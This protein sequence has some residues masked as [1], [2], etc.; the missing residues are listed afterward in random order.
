MYPGNGTFYSGVVLSFSVTSF[1]SQAQTVFVQLNW[2][3]LLLKYAHSLLGLCSR[4]EPSPQAKSF[5][6]KRKKAIQ[7]HRHLQWGWYLG[8][9]P[10]TKG[11]TAPC[12]GV[13]WEAS[14]TITTCRG[15]WAVLGAGAW[16]RFW[17]LL[18]LLFLTPLQGQLPE[19]QNQ[20]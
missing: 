12:D 6:D 14:R 1:Q 7:F 16:R 5:T 15:A 8:T 19:S 18:S 20:W 13:M 2:P 3:L 9:K 10:P 4:A 11:P 17:L